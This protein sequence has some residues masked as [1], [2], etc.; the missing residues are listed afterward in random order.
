MMND[1]LKAAA[2]AVAVFAITLSAGVIAGKARTPKTVEMPT[3]TAQLM[4]GTTI[5]VTKE[6]SDR[7]DRYEVTV[8][9]LDIAERK[10]ETKELI[11]HE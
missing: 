8:C 11:P 6:G 10:C 2:T 9:R 1:P 7:P 4:D 5:A 3:M